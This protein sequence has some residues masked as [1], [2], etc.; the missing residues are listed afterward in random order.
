MS[1]A[2]LRTADVIID[3]AVAFD[4]SASNEVNTVAIETAL[5]ALE[6]AGAIAVTFDAET[7]EVTMEL[8]PLL[9]AVNMSIEML[10]G[11]LALQTGSDRLT[12]LATLR[13]HLHAALD[14]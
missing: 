10:A 9:T 14:G 5:S 13:E 3:M 11:S 8:T 6:E 1:D 7:N 2:T 12:I 4:E